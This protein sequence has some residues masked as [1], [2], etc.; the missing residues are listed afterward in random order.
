VLSHGIG[1]PFLAKEIHGVYVMHSR[2]GST[3]RPVWA[4]TL[5]G[6]PPMAARGSYGD[7]IPVWQRNHMRNVLDA[8]SGEVLFATNSPQPE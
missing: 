6:L 2:M 8:R 1:S 5:R 3:P 4:I 7:T